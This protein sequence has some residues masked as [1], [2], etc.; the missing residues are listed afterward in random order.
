MAVFDANVLV[1]LIVA[2]PW[3]ESARR[4]VAGRPIRMAP[5]LATV[6]V[7]NAIWQNVRSGSL[8]A[9]HAEF[10]LR[11][12]MSS[13]TLVPVDDL[14]AAAL[15]IAIQY[16]HPIYDCC[17]LAL[18]QRDRDTLVT[19]DGRLAALAERVGVWVEYIS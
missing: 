14:V 8:A 11:K 6:E 10:S 16:G 5:S 19:A 12:A 9:D 17:Y 3:S 7:G 13:M 15:R 18:A 4:A 2:L 1:A